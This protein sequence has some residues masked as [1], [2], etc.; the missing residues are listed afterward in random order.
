MAGRRAAMALHV[1]LDLRAHRPGL[2]YLPS[3][4]RKLSASAV[5]LPRYSRCVADGATLFFL[6]QKTGVDRTVQ[7]AAK[8][9][10]YFVDL[11][12][13]RGHADRICSLQAGA[14]RMA[15]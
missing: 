6:W 8:A 2:R 10:L 1:C 15:G 14:A 12:R 4:F 13:S 3:R 7:S 11:L 9:G 5:H